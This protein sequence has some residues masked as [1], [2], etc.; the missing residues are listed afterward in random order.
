MLT[1]SCNLHNNTTQHPKEA[2]NTVHGRVLPFVTVGL[3]GAV[4]AAAQH[5]RRTSCL[6]TN[7]GKDRHLKFEVR[8]L[9]IAC[10]TIIITSKTIVSQG[11][12]E[13]DQEF[14]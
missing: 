8:F 2:G 6:I 4:A 7:M 11:P 9:L 1:V 5:H 3:P 10:H 13:L 14:V 12:S